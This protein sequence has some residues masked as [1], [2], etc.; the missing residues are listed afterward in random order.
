M[1]KNEKSNN[2]R[3]QRKNDN[4][5]HRHSKRVN[6]LKP[7]NYLLPPKNDYSELTSSEIQ[8]L[9][10][11][12]KQYRKL[13]EQHQQELSLTK[14][15]QSDTKNLYKNVAK[16]NYN[17]DY[18]QNI[19]SSRM[20]QNYRNMNNRYNISPSFI[21]KP[22]VITFTT[23]DHIFYVTPK[24]MQKLQTVSSTV[25]TT[26]TT[27]IMFLFK[28]PTNNHK[29]HTTTSYDNSNNN[30]NN[31]N[32]LPVQENL[33]NYYTTTAT[34]NKNNLIYRTNTIP[35]VPSDITV[36]TSDWL[37][38]SH[39]Q[40]YLITSDQN[41]L[42][43]TIN[44]T[45]TGKIFNN[46]KFG[47]KNLSLYYFN[48]DNYNSEDV[49]DNYYLPLNYSTTVLPTSTNE[50]ILSK[51]KQS[52]IPILEIN[53]ML[54]KELNYDINKNN[55]NNSDHY[56]VNKF[57]QVP[58]LSPDVEKAGMKIYK[59]NDKESEIY[60]P[61]TNSKNNSNLYNESNKNFGV[62]MRW[63]QIKSVENNKESNN[64]NNNNNHNN[65]ENYGEDKDLKLSVAETTHYKRPTTLLKKP[66]QYIPQQTFVLHRHVIPGAAGEDYP[67]L[68][69]PPINSRFSCKND[70]RRYI[71]DV[72][73]G[74]QVFFMCVGDG[75]GE[76]MLCPNGTLF[77]QDFLVCDWWYNVDCH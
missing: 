37:I 77:S 52:Q 60:L 59:L 69:R 63:T 61:S 1:V 35:T 62:R 53:S 49:K 12:Y 15:L 2:S 75:P 65:D 3:R 71:A 19:S 30:N 67:T 24:F 7:V 14:N 44:T 41:I 64:N 56:S 58:L 48:N 25:T 51:L 8:P 13:L 70:G 54:K 22:P 45:V 20:E 27:P 29:L 23:S 38:S 74:C 18:K 46:N 40:K 17:N 43:R 21:L 31:N 36:T 28:S 68:S 50:Y 76:A 4:N 11:A 16:L 26:A 33:E 34:T 73:S 42:N 66:S 5:R 32:I 9:K 10:T 39:P 47:L 72:S 55:N 57:T 6:I